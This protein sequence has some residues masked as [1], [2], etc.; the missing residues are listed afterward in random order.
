MPTRLPS[1]RALRPQ[2]RISHPA[3]S[4]GA[5]VSCSAVIRRHRR[6]GGRPAHATRRPAHY[7]H[8]VVLTI[9]LGL[10][11]AVGWGAPDAVLAR[12]VRQIGAFPVVFGSILIGT[13]IASPLALVLDAPDWSERSL[14]L[15]P[16]VGILT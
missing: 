9:L 12:A 13:L 2:D 3:G 6:A 1:R 15:A 14:V 4:C 11:S 16:V 8:R 10:T 7:P 5:P